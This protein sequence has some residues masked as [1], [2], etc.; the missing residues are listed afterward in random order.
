MEMFVS[1][2]QLFEQVR[3]E[4]VSVFHNKFSAI[5]AQSVVYYLIRIVS[6]KNQA[7]PLTGLQCTVIVVTVLLFILTVV[8]GGLL[9]ILAQ[10]GLKNMG[11]AMQ[12]TISLVHKIAPYIISI[13]MRVTLHLLL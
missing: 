10:D 9:S 3:G 5:L 1:T 13:A 4:K 6:L 7:A 2:L 8:V 12:N 11:I